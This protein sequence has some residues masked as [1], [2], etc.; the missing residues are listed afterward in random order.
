MKK[1][2]KFFAKVNKVKKPEEITQISGVIG[3]LIDNAVNEIFMTYKAELLNESITYIVPAV[4]GAKKDGELTPLQRE[5]HGRIA[6]VI[7]QVYEALAL[8]NLNESQHFAIGFIIRGL[9]VSKMVYMVEAMKNRVDGKSRT[10][11]EDDKILK[12]MEP[13]GKG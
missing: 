10:E 3:P 6:P 2:G 12:H 9:I 1:F 7:E 8:K 4:W 13:M 5:I 11:D